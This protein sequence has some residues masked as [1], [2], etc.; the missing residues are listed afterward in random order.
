MRLRIQANI[1]E[2]LE[3]QL[4]ADLSPQQK[5]NLQGLVSRGIKE[6]EIDESG[7][8]IFTLTDN[9]T[10]DLGNVVGPPGATT[11]EALTNKPFTSI[12]SNLK[13]VNGVL[14][15]DTASSAQQDN[16]KPITSAAVYTEVGNISA[17][18]S[19]I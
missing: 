17:L 5:A 11:W 18:L 13:V 10:V 15:V 2:S 7:H 3:A 9:T 4:K 1:I 16:T 14:A 12:G 6:A 19:L 8:L